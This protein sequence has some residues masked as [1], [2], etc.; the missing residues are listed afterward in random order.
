MDGLLDFLNVDLLHDLLP[1]SWFD[2][3]HLQFGT[4]L[5][6]EMIVQSVQEASAFFNMNAPMNIH[7]D[8]TTGVMTGMTFTENDDILVFNR[9]QMLDMGISDKQGF[10]LVMTH[11]G[12]HRALQGLDTGFSSHQEELCCDYM[13]GVRAGLNGMDEGKIA[14][15][16]ADTNETSSH[17]DGALRVQAIEAGVSFAHEYMIAHNGVPPTFSDCLEHFSQTEVFTGT[18]EPEHINLRP[19]HTIAEGF[20]TLHPDV[21]RAIKGFTQ[22]DVDFYEH[23][24]RITSG[25][26]QAVWLDKAQWARNHI[27]SFAPADSGHENDE[28]IVQEMELKSFTQADVEWYEHQARISSGSEQAHWL[29]EAQWARDHIHGFVHETVVPDMGD[30][31]MHQFG[32]GRFGN[33]TG[34]YIDDSFPEDDHCHGKLHALFVDDRAYH[35]REAQSAQESA[36]WHHKR[37]DAA[38]ERGDM[39]SAR[40]H[41]AR[42]EGYEKARKDHLA[43]AKKCTK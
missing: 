27:H 4:E 9:Q 23:Q 17:P 28:H 34:D 20:S 8:W 32:G 38:I 14:A 15:S 22:A 37:A 2:N 6:D 1:S 3:L 39:S 29:K 16:L 33:A 43:A 18:L 41:N 26:E 35:L 40:D 30:Q 42:A 24:A 12:A 21:Q 13:A 31:E 10:D 7:E 25:S 36:E 5:T 19:E 11:E